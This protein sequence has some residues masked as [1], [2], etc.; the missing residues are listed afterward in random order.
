MTT[1]QLI[2]PQWLLIKSGLKTIEIRL[3]AAKRQALQVGDI[4]NFIDLTT[5]QQLTTQLID[6]TRFASF[7]SLLSEYTAV[8]VGSAP[9]T[10]VTQ[11][12]QEML[13][14]YSPVQVAQSGVVALQIRPLIG[15]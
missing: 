7:E 6:I 1:M 11:M 9:G 4:V 3:N 15:Q 13:T 2:H 10:P 12:V 5:G 14:L 8:Q